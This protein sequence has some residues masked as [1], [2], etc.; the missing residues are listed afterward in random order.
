MFNK[1]N[2]ELQVIQSH[3]VCID[4][5]QRIGTSYAL[6]KTQDINLMMLRRSKNLPR[7]VDIVCSCDIRR[8]RV[9]DITPEI[10]LQLSASS[11]P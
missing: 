4:W 11:I 3:S 2:V 6:W 10:A 7:L 9:V 8:I 1:S 5:K